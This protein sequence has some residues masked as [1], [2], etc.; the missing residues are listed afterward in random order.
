MKLGIICA[1]DVEAALLKEHMHNTAVTTYAHM[2]YVEGMLEDCSVVVVRCGIGKSNAAVCVQNLVNHFGVTHIINSGA[3][4]S[5]DNRIDILDIVVSTDVIHHDVDATIFG[6]AAGEV[7]GL[8]VAAFPADEA[9]RRVVLQAIAQAHEKYAVFEGRIASGD[10]FIADDTTKAHIRDTFHA[11]CCEMEGASIAQACWLNDLPFVIIRAISDKADDSKQ[12]EY[13]VFEK[14]AAHQ[15]A[16]VV[17]L[18]A[19][20]LAAH[21]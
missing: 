20:Q 17:M 7:P 16:K 6:Y 18:V 2:D 19:A 21:S 4:G 3:A 13:P 1:M 5:L 8:G 14:I 15:S 11:C 9:L 12:I 10:Q